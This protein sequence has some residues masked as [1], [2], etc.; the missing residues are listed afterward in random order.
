MCSFCA[1][2]THDDEI[3]IFVY[4]NVKYGAYIKTVYFVNL[5]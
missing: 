3:F 4:F 2:Q 5:K 1:Y